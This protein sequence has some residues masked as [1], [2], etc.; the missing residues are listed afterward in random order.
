MVLFV[1]VVPGLVQPHLGVCCC[2]GFFPEVVGLRIT[3]CR[4]MDEEA[5]TADVSRRGMG[6]RQGEG[7][8]YGRINGVA[9]LPEHLRPGFGGQRILRHHHAMA[10][11][12]RAV[13][14]QR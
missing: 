4:T 14:R 5:A 9:A 3:L 7:R 1:V 2:R 13:G 10:G 11:V 12:L 8:G 6:H